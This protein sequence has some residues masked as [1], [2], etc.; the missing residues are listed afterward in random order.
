MLDIQNYKTEGKK[1]TK[2]KK[3]EN[4]HLTMVTCEKNT[5]NF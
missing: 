2:L 5:V 3:K 4:S 1:I